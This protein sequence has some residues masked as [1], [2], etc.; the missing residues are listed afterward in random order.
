MA[1]QDSLKKKWLN[2]TSVGSV[3]YPKLSIILII[4]KIDQN[5]IQIGQILEKLWLKQYSTQCQVKTPLNVGELQI[6]ALKMA[7]WPKLLDCTKLGRLFK[8]GIKCGWGVGHMHLHKNR[9]I[10]YLNKPRLWAVA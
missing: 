3:T 5:F 1:L 2:N 4:P 9:R 7:N 10:E 6:G 8:H